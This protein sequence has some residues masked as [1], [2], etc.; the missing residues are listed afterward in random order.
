[1]CFRSQYDVDIFPEI[2]YVRHNFTNEQKKRWSNWIHEH[3]QQAAID[4]AREAK[5]KACF[6]SAIEYAFAHELP[7]D[8]EDGAE[9][10]YVDLTVIHAR[11]M[12]W[13]NF[14]NSCRVSF[15]KISINFILIHF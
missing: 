4:A 2:N 8:W 5:N 15:S 1:M 12:F 9:I 14:P 13:K 7:E 10:D 3:Q 6:S 11:K